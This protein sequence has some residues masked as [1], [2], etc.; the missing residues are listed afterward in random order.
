MV[1]PSSADPR[2][3]ASTLTLY[4][5]LGQILNGSQPIRTKILNV[6][7]GKGASLAYPSSRSMFITSHVPLFCCAGA[8]T[9]IFAVQAFICKAQVE[10]S[11]QGGVQSG[12]ML[13]SE[14]VAV[15]IEKVT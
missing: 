3:A 8:L 9:S 4:D 6:W 7:G 12:F 13:L 2:S 5:L 11:S 10:D 14:M 15:C 1:F